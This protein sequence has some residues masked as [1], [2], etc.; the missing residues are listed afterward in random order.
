MMATTLKAYGRLDCAFNN[1]GI[2]GTLAGV[3][4]KLTAE[5][6]EE[7][8]DRLVQVNL[9]GTWL[10]MRAEIQQMVQQ[11]SGSI[12]NTAS[13]AGLTGFRT[14]AGYA[15]SKHGVVGLTKTAA[16]EYAPTVRV[17]CVC[18]GWIATDMIASAIEQRGDAILTE[19]A[20]KRFGEPEDIGEMVCWLLSDC[21]GYAV[22]G[23]F[24][25]DGGQMA[26]EPVI[27]NSLGRQRPGPSPTASLILLDGLLRWPA[28][29]GTPWQ[30]Q[31]QRAREADPQRGDGIWYVAL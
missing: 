24:I 2:N 23:A 26:S 5:W 7:A 27:S 22:G 3:G 25:V 29:T 1:A 6:T 16:I 13:L 14:T 19:V 30:E 20:S 12:V 8:F 18:P 21:A 4:G 17:N 11:G 31:H 9:K 10:C 28:A 15:A